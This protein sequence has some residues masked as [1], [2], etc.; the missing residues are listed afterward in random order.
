MTDEQKTEWVLNY[1]RAMTQE[2]AEL[3]DSVPEMV[4]Q[5]PEAR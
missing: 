4:G 1:S 5:V 2:I 3:T